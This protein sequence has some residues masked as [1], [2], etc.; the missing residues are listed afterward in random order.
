MSLE[1]SRKE[2]LPRIFHKAK[3]GADK[4]VLVQTCK[5]H[6][7]ELGEGDPVIVVPG[8]YALY[9]N[10]NRLLP[11]LSSGHRLMELDYIG[12]GDP[13]KDDARVVYSVPEQSDLIANL[14]L[15]LGLGKVNL[16]GSC[17]SSPLVFDF[18]SRYP[19]L[20]DKIVSIEGGIV[21]SDKARKTK[22]PWFK[23]LPSRKTYSQIEE[24]A[25]AI[26]CPIL[27]IYGSQ[28]GCNDFPL[29]I[30]LEYFKAYL[31]QAWIVSFE[32]S[33]NDLILQSPSEITALI[34][35]FLRKNQG[36][37]SPAV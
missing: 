25:R 28:F 3:F 34:L 23:K 30:N 24:S 8:S 12:I 10:W 2:I 1:R 6:Y 15:Q 22:L 18:A 35:E 13:E 16:I 20:I 36:V 19:E 31:P 7:V 26:K 37:E 29:D 4:L 27:Y 32:G 14:T 17:F 9:R 5:V 11:L 21:E 33:I